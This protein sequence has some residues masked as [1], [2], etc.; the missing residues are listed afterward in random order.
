MNDRIDAKYDDNHE[1]HQHSRSVYCDSDFRIDDS[2]VDVHGA[3]SHVVNFNHEE[4]TKDK[5]KQFQMQNP[6]GTSNEVTEPTLEKT[7]L[8]KIPTRKAVSGTHKTQILNKFPV[9]CLEG[10]YC[11]ANAIL[12]GT[13]KSTV[14]LESVRGALCVVYA[15]FDTMEPD[16]TFQP[17]MHELRC[18]GYFT[19]D[20][21]TCIFVLQIYRVHLSAVGTEG[22]QYICELRRASN[23][24]RESFDFLLN[25][26]AVSLK[27]AGHAEK[28]AN[29]FEIY[30]PLSLGMDV[31][32]S[33]DNCPIHLSIDTSRRLISRVAKQKYPQY[34]PTLRLLAK[35]SAA[36]R[37]NRS[38]L[39]KNNELSEVVFRELSNPS[40][41]CACLNALKLIELGVV[42]PKEGLT[43]IVKSM[44]V[45]CA[46]KPTGFKGLRSQAIENAA[47]GAMRVLSKTMSVKDNKEAILTIECFL[48]GKLKE[49]LYQKIRDIFEDIYC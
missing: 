47:L 34:S 1:L 24:G 44:L 35:I 8:K 22:I 7:I 16:L 32:W 36:S 42:A 28:Y 25:A 45:Y 15:F 26:V 3:P 21:D 41:A 9:R 17:C 19:H 37:D 13:P 11:Q 18:L 6:T 14:S 30:P 40:E 20:F 39:S 5:E 23:N 31:W 10:Y 4:I 48:F 46:K 27:Q 49:E 2:T 33:S 38:I 12:L 43:G 29:G